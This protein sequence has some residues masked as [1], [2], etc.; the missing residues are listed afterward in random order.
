M[1]GK[2]GE[3]GNGTGVKWVWHEVGCVDG[4]M[5]EAW[6]KKMRCGGIGSRVGGLDA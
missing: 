6:V 3:G 5:S 2:G 4:C 1:N